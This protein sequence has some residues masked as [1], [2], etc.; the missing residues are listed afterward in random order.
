MLIVILYMSS[1]EIVLV[2]YHQSIIISV[3]NY[4]IFIHAF[5]KQSFLLLQQQWKLFFSPAVCSPETCK[6][7]AL[8]RSFLKQYAV[9]QIIYSFFDD[10]MNSSIGKFPLTCNNND[11]N[12][13]SIDYFTGMRWISLGNSGL[14]LNE[15]PSG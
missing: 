5:I 3:C 11:N 2:L 4:A 12:S 14:M 1:V 8:H 6:R 13:N 9:C 10:C 7:S 15:D